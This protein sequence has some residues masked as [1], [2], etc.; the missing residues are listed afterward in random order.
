MPGWLRHLALPSRVLIAA[1]CASCVFAGGGCGDDS[2]S[3]NDGDGTASNAA[4]A[5]Q[6]KR[7]YTA[8]QGGDGKVA[9]R[10]L[11][12]KAAK[13]FEA[14]VTGRVSDD[15][16]TNIEALSRVNG[17]RGTPQ[18]TR[19]Q[20]TGNQAT[21][22]V[23][24]EDPPLESDVVLVRERGTWRLAQLPAFVERGVSGTGS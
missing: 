8:L 11:T 23:V 10:L 21:A 19:V 24:F 13:G 14:V 2:G 22:H 6:V 12:R 18:V 9:C 7:Y 3:G 15:C 4:I 17:L 20:S 5:G 16:E 1:L